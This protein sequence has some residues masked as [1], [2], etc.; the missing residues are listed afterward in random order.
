[1]HRVLQ[2]GGTPQIGLATKEPICYLIP[3]KEKALLITTYPPR[4]VLNM[5]N[6]ASVG[7]KVKNLPFLAH[8]FNIFKH[9]EEV[10]QYNA[11]WQWVRDNWAKV[12]TKE[13]GLGVRA[14]DNHPGGLVCF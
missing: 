6:K 1:M 12:D 11:S 4:Y 14:N 5:E 10:I 2:D 3:K 8:M 9:G 7:V 13:S